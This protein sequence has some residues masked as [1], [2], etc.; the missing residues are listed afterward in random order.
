MTSKTFHEVF[1][2]KLAAM[3]RLL[4]LTTVHQNFSKKRKMGVKMLMC[5]M[6]GG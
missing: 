4:T 3:R 5:L 2:D 6:R 1:A